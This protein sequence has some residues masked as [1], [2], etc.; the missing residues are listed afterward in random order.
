VSDIVAGL[1]ERIRAIEGR[2]AVDASWQPSG[3]PGLDHA[4]GGVPRPGVVELLG[5]TGSGRTRLALAL[6]RCCTA[7]GQ[8]AAWLDVGQVFFPPAAAAL[9]V[10]LDQLLLLR[11]P[12]DQGSWAVEQVLRSGCFPLVVADGVPEPSG[13]AAR[14]GRAAHTGCSTLVVVG[15][16]PLRELQVGLRLVVA[17]GQVSV[18]RHRSGRVGGTFAVPPWPEGLDPWA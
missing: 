18:Q 16:Q 4:A 15:A 8:P 6:V 10:D 14:W 1:R 7:Q 13:A 5:P 17:R 2:P 3:V 9:G 12:A 11:P